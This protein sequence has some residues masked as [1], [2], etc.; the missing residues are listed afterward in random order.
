MKQLTIFYQQGV[1]AGSTKV[2]IV[3]AIFMLLTINKYDKLI[4]EY[5][6]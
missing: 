4:I 6:S 3:R 1:E 5:F 2:S